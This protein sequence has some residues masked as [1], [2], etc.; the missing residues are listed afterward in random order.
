M[1]V[2]SDTILLGSYPQNGDFP[3]R[4]PIEWI[5]LEKANGQSLCISRFLLDCKPY[6]RTPGKI[7]WKECSLRHWLNYD[8]FTYSFTKEEQER[9]SLSEIKNP[10]SNTIDRVF[11]LNLDEAEHYFNFENR[12]AKV[13]HFAQ[14]Q[15]AWSMNECGVWWLRY[16]GAE[17]IMEEGELDGISCVNFDGYIEEN[18]SEPTDSTCSV[19]PVIWLKR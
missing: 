17:E 4:E 13:T 5:I 14:K 7:I 6:H 10:K 11:L 2:N 16:S 9:I 3:K 18:A 12:A 8:F 19:R 1:C 15:G